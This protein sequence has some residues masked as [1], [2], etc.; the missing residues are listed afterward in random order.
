MGGL[1]VLISWKPDPSARND[2]LAWIIPTHTV[3]SAVSFSLSVNVE[4]LTLTGSA[5]I[6]ATGN[7][8]GNILTGNTAANTL[9][10]LAGN[11]T[12]N[13]GAGADT[14]LGGLG[15]ATLQG[16]AAVQFATLTTKPTIGANDFLVAA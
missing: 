14:L 2:W 1:A 11:D 9:S 16:G 10:G 4:R 8:L 3:Q 5:V 15:N 7:E 12:L 6:D 13:G